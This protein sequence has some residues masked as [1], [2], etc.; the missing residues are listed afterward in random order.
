M[1]RV[2]VAFCLLF[3]SHPPKCASTLVDLG[4]PWCQIPEPDGSG[5]VCQEGGTFRSTDA[6]VR[7]PAGLQ[8]CR[9]L[10]A[11]PGCRE[12]EAGCRSPPP[13]T[14]DLEQ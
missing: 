1:N 12:R 10:K 9:A 8:G 4:T 7:A 14:E 5:S 6:A 11:T 13:C 2:K 3:L